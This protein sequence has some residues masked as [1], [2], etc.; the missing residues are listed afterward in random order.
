MSSKTVYF[1]DKCQKKIENKRYKIELSSVSAW[2]GKSYDLCKDCY[3]DI[4]GIL[5]G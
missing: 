1:C 3:E 5:G 4:K 2:T